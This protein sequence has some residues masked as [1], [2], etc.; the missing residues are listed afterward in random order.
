MLVAER[1]RQQLSKQGLEMF[2]RLFLWEES[3]E[4][5]CARTGQTAT[6][7][8]QWRSRLKRLVQ[9][10]MRDESP[11]FPQLGSVCTTEPGAATVATGA[12]WLVAKGE[13]HRD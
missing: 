7:V 1:L 2:Y 3:V 12:S 6:T 10:L 5:I 8:Y 9:E 4:E 13:S 11:P